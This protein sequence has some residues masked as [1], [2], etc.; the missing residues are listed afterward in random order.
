MPG[1]ERTDTTMRTL[2]FLL[3]TLPLAAFAPAQKINDVVVK[4][5]GSR[6]RG[7]EITEFLLSGV[8]GKRG[9]DAFEVPGHTVVAV[10]W[11]DPPEAFVTGR[12][13]LDRGDFRTATQLFGDVQTPRALVKVDAE[14]FKIKAAI[15]GI[16]NDKAAAATAAAHAKKWLADNQNH[17]RTPEAMLLAGRAERLA[18]TGGAATA[19]LRELDERATREAFGAIWN[20]RAK[21]ELA[22]TL[23]ADGKAGEARTAFQSA[24]AA[25]DSALQ[26][27]SADD[28]ELRAL[29]TMA[30]V[31]EG[32][33]FLADKDF[34][35]AESFFRSL[36]S[37]NQ[38]ELVAAGHAGVGEAVFL[39][40]AG[41]NNP[42]DLRRAQIAFATAAV[43]DVQ[44]GEASAKA[45][46]YLGRCVLQLQDREGD[47][48]KQRANAYFQTVISSYPTS[49]WAGPAKV[50]LGK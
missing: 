50:E 20:A 36:I 47:A 32:E 14:F 2:S 45:N 42:E 40:A 31:G 49:R 21:S 35:K 16:G 43:L 30:R 4:K 10:E 28:A 8:R 33:T 3:A 25:A 26:T 48:W 17:W 11:S 6:V 22:L 23:V 19:S 29:K 41:A 24:A 34:A 38:A 27:P 39:A 13:A 9:A 12:A 46:Y 5:D 1:A 37:S 7:V 15:A 18:G 44:S